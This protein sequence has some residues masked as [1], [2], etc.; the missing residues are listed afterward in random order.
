MIRDTKEK[1]KLSENKW[2][3]T[4]T[5]LNKLSPRY[6]E[7][8]KLLKSRYLEL[9]HI[10]ET[11]QREDKV[12]KNKVL[13]KKH[14]IRSIS[15]ENLIYINKEESNALLSK[16]YKHKVIAYQ[17]RNHTQELDKEKSKKSKDLQ[18]DYESA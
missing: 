3:D 4:S 7:A 12:K 11:K 1:L 15:R 14:S 9:K 16:Q 10:I 17:E 2:E 18:L 13:E 8:A 6:S 5:H